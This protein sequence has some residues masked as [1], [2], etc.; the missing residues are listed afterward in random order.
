VVVV[1][2]GLVAVLVVVVFLTVAV[3][4]M[5]L[6]VWFVVVLFTVGNALS[7]TVIA[8]SEVLFEGAFITYT[9]Y[10]VP[11]KKA[12]TTKI[13]RYTFPLVIPELFV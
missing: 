1:L 2:F 5:V 8:T 6:I 11:T 9:P 4:V 12:A 3:F 10:P 7:E 13:N